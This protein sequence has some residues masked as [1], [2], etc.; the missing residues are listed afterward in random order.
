[1]IRQTKRSA[2]QFWDNI[3]Y[4]LKGDTGGVVPTLTTSNLVMNFNATATVDGSVITPGSSSVTEYGFVWATHN[5][6]TIA[7][8]KVPIISESDSN[9]SGNNI[10]PLTY[11]DTVYFAAYATNAAGTGYG[12]VLSGQV[13]ICF[14]AGTR[15]TTPYG[16]KK[17]EDVQ[18]SDDLLAWN[19]DDGTFSKVKPVWMV[20]PFKS[21]YYSVLKFDN[22]DEL[23]TV[24]DGRGHRIFNLERNM[25][26]YSMSDDTPIGTTTITHE[27]ELTKLTSKDVLRGD[28]WFYNI[29][30]HT[31]I[32]VYANGVLTSTG[33][34]NIYPIKGM[35][36]V[37]DDRTLRSREE[38][39]VSEELFIGLRLAEQPIVN[40]PNLKDK[41]KF[42]VTRQG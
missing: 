21:S 9:Y 35:K 1:M 38:F 14:A 19:F 5:N 18:Y 4:S 39:D 3:L 27:N 22:G 37:K 8:H 16:T 30:T 15:I 7:D 12:N 11:P 20:K 24:A 6:P 10:G 17:I 36:F 33:L 31:H 40:Y 42:M 13:Q 28:K 2:D 23:I 26:T 25:F 29:I 32:N 41:I 34:N